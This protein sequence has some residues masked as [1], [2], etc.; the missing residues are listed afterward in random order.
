MTYP[1]DH[2]EIGQCRPL[3]FLSYSSYIRKNPYPMYL[4]PSTIWLILFGFWAVIIGC[5]IY[6]GYVQVRLFHKGLLNAH[7][8]LGTSM[9]KSAMQFA[10]DRRDINMIRRAK[11]LFNVSIIAFLSFMLGV[12]WL[13]V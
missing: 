6:V 13:A 12:T 2:A 7:W 1:H 3:D 9:L 11:V 10:T 4:Q 8:S 5:N